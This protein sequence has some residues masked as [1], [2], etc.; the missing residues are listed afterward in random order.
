MELLAPGAQGQTAEAY[1]ETVE[2]FS[3]RSPDQYLVSGSYY[4]NLGRLLRCP[5]PAPP[6]LDPFCFVAV[7][8]LSAPQQNSNDGQPV[9]L[10]RNFREL[11]NPSDYIQGPQISANHSQLIFLRGHPSGAWLSTLGA[12]LRVDPEFWRRH[13]VPAHRCEYHDLPPLPSF[14]SR[15]VQLRVS[16]IFNCRTTVT[17]KAVEDARVD[18]R[19]HIRKHHVELWRK[20]AAGDSVVRQLHAHSESIYSVEQHISCTV[21]TKNGGWAALI[22]QD[23]GKPISE[24]PWM[25]KPYPSNKNEPDYCTPI[26]QPTAKAALS[27]D[28]LDDDGRSSGIPPSVSEVQSSTQSSAFLASPQY[29]TSLRESLMCSSPLY[30]L[31]DIFR[32]SACSSNQVLNML[33]Q[34][35]GDALRAADRLESLSLADLRFS[36]EVLDDRA[37]YLQEVINF[38][39]GD[40][41]LQVR[42]TTSSSQSQ[43]PRRPTNLSPTNSGSSST[44]NL[45][46]QSQQ[47]GDQT[48]RRPSLIGDTKRGNGTAESTQAD[49]LEDFRCLLRRTEK[50][51][52]R[53]KDGT[54]IILSG[55]Q[56]RESQKAINQA[57]EVRLLTKLVF[58][59]APLSFLT[60]VFGMNFVT[61]RWQQGLPALLVSALIIVFTLFV[62][63]SES[64]RRK[65]GEIISSMYYY[66]W[67]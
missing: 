60:S 34:R 64:A 67:R 15:S 35:V 13:Q 48:P 29:G 4:S 23:I 2:A 52:A 55:A 1:S 18:A 37:S 62:T 63:F 27:H 41:W 54:D 7:L 26:I 17:R 39:E 24:I 49:L 31:S 5:S 11:S 6:F 47:G 9:D 36:K 53:C 51:S 44:L 32:H 59:F 14:S 50:L 22:W 3:S 42:M 57:E 30:A 61:L 40:A 10:A 38:L 8:D 20:G 16:T 28:P 58:V 56:L 65:L 33:H 25:A 45:Q 43:V 66:R 46:G 12:A 21:V 19:E